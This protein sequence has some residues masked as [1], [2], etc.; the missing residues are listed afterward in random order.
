MPEVLECTIFSVVF[1]SDRNSFMV[2][3]VKCGKHIET[4]AGS[5]PAVHVGE[6]VR[7]TG[8]W[9]EHPKFGKQFAVTGCEVLAP[10]GES[11]LIAYLS[12]GIFAGIG[13]KTAEKLV[14]IFGEDLPHV[15]DKDPGKLRG[16]VRG[17]SGKKLE[18]FLD[19]WNMQQESRK[20]LLFLYNL[21]FTGAK[22]MNVWSMHK[23]NTENIVSE[24]P[25]A[26]C[27]DPFA[28]NFEIA[29]NAAKK[30]GFEASANLRLRAAITQVLREAKYDG[31]H[32]FMPRENLL[33]NTMNFLRI[34]PHS[35]DDDVFDDLNAALSGLQKNGKVHVQNERVWLPEL[36]EAEKY[37]GTFIRRSFDFNEE[38][39]HL[40]ASADYAASVQEIEYSDE[41]LL[42]IKSAVSS[43]FFVIT[44]G[45]GTGKTTILKG[46][47]HI[48]NLQKK[49]VKLAA[50]TGR[51]ARRMAEVCSFKAS[52][53]HRLLEIDPIS[54]LFTRDEMNPLEADSVI[55]D[56]SSM[57]DNELAAD[58]MR[59]LKAGTQLI[60]IGDSDQLPSVGPGNVLREILS[61][62]EVPSIR[63]SK[64]Y[65]H[66]DK[67]D[68]AENAHRILAGHLPN[69]KNGSH[70]RYMPYQHS[71]EALSILSELSKNHELQV[72]TPM[73]KGT[74]GT[75]NLNAF[76]QKILNFNAYGFEYR[77][78]RWQIG[79]PVMQLKNNYDKDIFNGDLGRITKV[80]PA[81]KKIEAD[82]DGKTINIE[83]NEFE[84]LT[85]AYACTV[86]KSQGSEY[87]SVVVMLDH[88]HSIMLQRNLLYTAVTRAKENIWVL[89]NS[90]SLETAVRNNRERHRW[91]ALREFI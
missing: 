68:I 47:L 67:S 81:A 33:Q 70:F 9:S 2:V 52:T 8:D 74:L 72:L 35:P 79:D 89:A 46:I 73:H 36:Y 77:G 17:L 56:E 48:L 63:L 60:L 51:A 23:S 31:G 34:I 32:A 13:E 69:V 86:H 4:A 80:M 83:S 16:A 29:D 25:Y 54:G 55:I 41:Q 42:A 14:A 58:L 40:D 57:I 62:P 27:E 44:G 45:P 5:F 1:A 75:I 84:H 22:A 53:I 19:D 85:L 39:S 90:G 38:T 82:F 49:K 26:L 12:S 87:K 76:L 61:C 21:G 28:Y 78:M 10:E 6:K 64:I 59:A 24:N 18:K 37:I 65:R 30:L 3:R 66:N 71:E 91:T 43:N 50:P 20:V 7:L 88:S 15:L 11:G